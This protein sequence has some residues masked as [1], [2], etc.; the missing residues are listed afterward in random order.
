MIRRI[1]PTTYLLIALIIMLVLH[2]ICPILMLISVPW[3]LVGIIPLVIGVLV[4]LLADAALHKGGTT[5][6]PFQES[7]SLI[8]DSVYRISR[9]P[10]Y[11]GFVLV[12]IG[13]AILLRSLS[14]WIVIP[15][16]IIL[17][18]LVFITEEEK[19]LAEKF[20]LTWIE[21]RNKVRQWI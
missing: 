21:Y 6:K 11:L 14:P 2:F 13:V 16:F 3:N 7:T 4:N 5:V 12:L 9:N 8:T 1:L 19:M 17:V 18:E 15:L 20:G 10:M